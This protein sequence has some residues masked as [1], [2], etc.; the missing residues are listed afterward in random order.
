MARIAIQFHALPDEL[1]SLVK[2]I[3]HDFGIHV[4]AM[5]FSPFEAIEVT[6]DTLDNVF[7][8][9]SPYEELALTVDRPVLPARSNTDFAEKNPNK[10][11]LDIRRVHP[12]GLR[13]TFLSAHSEDATALPLWKKIAQRLK[14]ATKAGVIVKNP[15]TGASVEDRTFRYSP[16]A[17]A[18][19]ARGVRML[20]LA[21]GNLIEFPESVH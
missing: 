4:T 9:N 20:P 13:Q 11:R 6:P 7:A 10:L 19:A 16:G 8:E 15:D 1:L 21:G 14:A 3:M 2:S 12:D 17:K 18:L 5:R